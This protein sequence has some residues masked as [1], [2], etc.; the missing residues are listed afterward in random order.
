MLI[1]VKVKS[2][3]YS[4]KEIFSMYLR[5]FWEKEYNKMKSELDAIKW[6]LNPKMY[7]DNNFIEELLKDKEESE[8]GGDF[9]KVYN[10]FRKLYENTNNG[11]FKNMQN[12]FNTITKVI[13][14]NEYSENKWLYKA[15]W[16]KSIKDNLLYVYNTN[17][18]IV[19][20]AFDI[21]M[22]YK[23]IFDEIRWDEI[24][25]KEFGLACKKYLEKQVS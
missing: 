24:R 12:I 14:V 2:K 23:K 8:R 1:F 22:Y 11:I 15:I 13:T 21:K 19:E 7:E 5:K 16:F 3:T 10:L 18:L 20:N 4:F 6:F 25:Y 9:L 17:Q